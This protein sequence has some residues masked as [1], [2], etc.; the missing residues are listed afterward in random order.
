MLWPSCLFQRR[1]KLCNWP[2]KREE[3]EEEEWRDGGEEEGQKQVSYAPGTDV[4]N[5]VR[6]RASGIFNTS[7]AFM[8]LRTLKGRQPHHKRKD[9]PLK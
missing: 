4:G 5:P 1:R 2:S 6:D 9:L 8:S 7:S 3:E